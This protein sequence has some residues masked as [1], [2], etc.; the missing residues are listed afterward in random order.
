MIKY[1]DLC[2]S[3][4]ARHISKM[5]KYFDMC[6]VLTLFLSFSFIMHHGNIP[7][8]PQWRMIVAE[9]EARDIKA[10]VRPPPLFDTN[11]MF[12]LHV[13]LTLGMGIWTLHCESYDNDAFSHRQ[14]VCAEQEVENRKVSRPSIANA[15]TTAHSLITTL[16][17]QNKKLGTEKLTFVSFWI[18]IL[19]ISWGMM[20]SFL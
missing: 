13:V 5:I 6:L 1:F 9:K 20:M 8:L 15:S 14:M 17:V 3:T 16:P 4:C 12:H 10:D 7:R 19:R 11:A 18:Q 2:T